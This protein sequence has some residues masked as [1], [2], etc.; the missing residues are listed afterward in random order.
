MFAV[1]YLPVQSLNFHIIPQKNPTHLLQFSKISPKKLPK[2]YFHD[3]VLFSDNLLPK[4]AKLSHP[5]R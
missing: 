2:S 3:P 4:S 1:L 5:H